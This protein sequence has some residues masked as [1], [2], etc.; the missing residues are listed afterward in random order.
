MPAEARAGINN[1]LDDPDTSVL[2]NAA[3]QTTAS[4]AA[5]LSAAR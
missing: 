3:P 5:V 1:V 2:D 4:A